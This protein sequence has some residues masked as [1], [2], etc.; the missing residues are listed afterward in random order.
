M[1]IKKTINKKTLELLIN[2]T[3]K[4]F[5]SIVTSK[6]LDSLKFLGFYYS[7]NAGIS[8]NIEDIK[9]N[10]EKKNIIENADN[11][12][13]IS[14]KNWE[15]GLI[16]YTERFENIID[17]WNI[18]TETLKN[19][20][21]DFYK[22]FDPVNNLFIM[23]F[24]GARG[25][26]SQVRQLVGM[27]GL[28]ADQ[29]GN[30]I[31]IPIKANFKEGLT[32]IDYI[33]SSYGARKGIVD[34]ALKTA[35][36]GYLTR[37]LIYVAQDIIIRE[38]DCKTT[39]GILI[40]FN[41]N[42][43]KNKLIGRYLNKIYN[44][45][46]IEIE[47]YLNNKII[48]NNV[49]NNLKKF[50]NI[51][52]NIRSI[53]NCK[54]KNSVCQKCYGWDLSK[55]KIVNLGES[56][57]II[58]A[59]SIGE[60]GTQLTMRTF[61]TG[62]IY[63]GELLKQITAQFSGKIIIPPDLKTIKY[64]INSGKSVLKL[65]ED[66]TILHKDWLGNINKI[67]LPIGSYLYI[68]KSK[69]LKIGELIAEIPKQKNFSKI[70]KLKPIYSTFSGEIKYENLSLRKV[71]FNKNVLKL[72]Q[73][74]GIIWIKS[75]NT[76]LIPTETKLS[77]FNKVNKNKPIGILKLIA[78]INGIF[79]LNNYSV[80]L[81]NS[82]EIIYFNIKNIFNLEN[83]NFTIKI[84]A[85]NYQYID[86]NTCFAHIYFYQEYDS[87]IYKIRQKLNT[88][89]KVLSVINDNNVWKF[90]TNFV[91]TSIT[92]EEIQ[93]VTKKI[94]NNTTI[95]QNGILI[96]KNGS[97]CIFQKIKP[98]F[99]NQGSIINFKQGD[100]ILNNEI[101]ATLLNF[102][103]Q[104]ED[105]VQ[106][107]PKIDELIE[108]RT[109]KDKSILCKNPI[110][111]LRNSFLNNKI[112]YKIDNYLNN[113]YINIKISEKFI[114]NFKFTNK[115]NLFALQNIINFK[116]LFIKNSKIFDIFLVPSDFN[117][118]KKNKNK[119]EEYFF[120]NKQNSI[121]IFNKLN[122]SYFI[123]NNKILENIN[124][125]IILEIFKNKYL[126][127]ESKNPFI[128]FNLNKINLSNIL[129]GNYV[130]IG[131]S[132]TDG[133][134]DINELLNILF[135]YHIKFEKLSKA[136]K[137]SINKFQ[138]ILINSI[139]SIYES[140]GVNISLKHIEI[141][142]NQMTSKV[143]ILEP[144]TTPLLCGELIKFDLINI[145]E[146]YFIK[147]KILKKLKYEPIILSVTN[148]S[149]TKDGFLSSA[150]FQ[151]TK[152]ILTKAAISS[153]TDWLKNLK[154]SIILGRIIPAGSSFLNY[155]NFLDNI[156][157]FKI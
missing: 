59:Q 60:P 111:V 76:F 149:L 123:K 127:L 7:T 99:I 151:E 24:S 75:T 70:Q 137:K 28:M 150:G 77:L 3:F 116:N 102:N 20:I 125:D 58:A 94:N 108:A 38:K 18:A 156:Y 33:I 118:V 22:E 79:S 47:S 154:E 96:R 130:D 89:Y 148:S 133:F 86:K 65:N 88:F 42:T 48:D 39:E 2:E 105:I 1:F 117:L 120:T 145:I 53:L 87:K 110:I 136:V 93:K 141:I 56:V 97:S 121:L 129:P 54:V 29:E 78:P 73:N 4:H 52:F 153:Q 8:I 45:H 12:I 131:E 55:I 134:I 135:N 91:N 142:V 147:N 6:L 92:S 113:K 37:R 57:G 68:Y 31:D 11:N 74:S 64:R 138:I 107:L 106:G 71:N 157:T 152:R 30:I 19:K 81:K 21:I 41:K 43:F 140:Q 36:S 34:T 124:G 66:T 84:L 85:K 27:R 13:L 35:D 46:G 67:Y 26:I 109:V 143:I 114:N 10:I 101:I 122:S 115:P 83:I 90:N 49:I 104:M 103:T 112:H 146:S 98:F 5:G 132:L 82:K 69:F 95:L 119:K 32:S 17:T 15:Y 51:F 126:F 44:K 14:S 144:G 9:T 23:A 61:H 139:Q 62:G 100:F 80:N 72:T 16:S 128:N 155:K 50:D 40:D 63:T 25:N